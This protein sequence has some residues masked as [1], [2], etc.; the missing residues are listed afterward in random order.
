LAKCNACHASLSL[1]GDNRNAIEQCVL[2][3]NP[4]GSD[5][6]RRPAEQNPAQS[7]DF[8]SMIHKIHTGKELTE[9]YVIFGFGGSVNSFNDVGFPG[10]RNNC[11]TCHVNG[12]EQLPLPATAAKVVNARGPIPLM[13]PETA[14][15]TSCHTSLAANSHALANT[16]AIGESCSACHGPTADFSVSNVHAQ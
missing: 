3:H 15:C 10:K 4:T 12:S 16:T 6:A 8:R 9:P 2:C 5:A 14:A 13:G 7:I 11:S 1:H